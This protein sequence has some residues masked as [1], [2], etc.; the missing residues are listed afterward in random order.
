MLTI[1]CNGPTI[2]DTTAVHTI[3]QDKQSVLDFINK[4][5]HAI[6]SEENIEKLDRSEITVL[7]KK[8]TASQ[9]LWF[10]ISN[11]GNKYTYKLQI[12]KYRYY[13]DPAYRYEILESR[14]GWSR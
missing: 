12:R 7:S 3:V 9:E 11:L 10:V 2:L 1:A 8:S 5:H 14:A 13:L 6:N 4:A